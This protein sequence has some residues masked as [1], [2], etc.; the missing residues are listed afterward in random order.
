MRTIKFRAWN[1]LD[2]NWLAELEL[3]LFINPETKGKY[4]YIHDTSNNG[5]DYIEISQFTG[6]KD[7]NRKESYEKDICNFRR[8][9]SKK[10]EVG[11]IFWSDIYLTY[12]LKC[13]YTKNKDSDFYSI[14]IEECKEIE[15]I[16]NI[17]ENPELL[18][19]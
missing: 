4:F 18:K 12:Y 14:R 7:K 13:F 19:L 3:A 10:W 2:K 16:G 15:I 17:Y 5:I 9:K 6:L 1:K 11:E 8:Y